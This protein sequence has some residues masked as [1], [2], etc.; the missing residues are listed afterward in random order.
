[1]LR[2]IEEHK[3]EIRTDSL[4]V[5]HIVHNLHEVLSLNP[6]GIGH[7]LLDSELPR[8]VWQCGLS[9]EFLVSHATV[10]MSCVTPVCVL[11]QSVCIIRDCCTV[12]WNWSVLDIVCLKVSSLQTVTPVYLSYFH[13]L[14]VSRTLNHVGIHHILVPHFRTW[15]VSCTVWDIAVVSTG[16]CMKCV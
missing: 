6:S 3:E 12:Q 14:K 10:V 13:L 9:N 5:L 7:T 11:N 1:M 15:N 16:V 2:S 8:Q 4:Q